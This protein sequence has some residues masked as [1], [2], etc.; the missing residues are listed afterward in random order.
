MFA[1]KEQTIN[2]MWEDYELTPNNVGEEY[3]KPENVSETSKKV[4]HLSIAHCSFHTHF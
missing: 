1:S 2:K 4:K 3:K